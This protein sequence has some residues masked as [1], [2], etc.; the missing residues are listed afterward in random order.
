MTK[1]KT[2]R[3]ESHQGFSNKTVE[4]WRQFQ[5][6]GALVTLL[7]L[8]LYV[9]ATSGLVSASFAGGSEGG[10]AVQFNDILQVTGLIFVLS[11]ILGLYVANYE[12]RLLLRHLQFASLIFL[13]LLM[14][15][16]VKIVAY[17]N[18]SPYLISV[19]VLIT[20]I[21]I[22]IAFSQR[23]AVGI[24]AFM[25]LISL[26]TLER[27]L[28]FHVEFSIL[29][30]TGCAMFVTVACLR[31]IRTRSSLILACCLA[32]VVLF[33]MVWFMEFWHKVRPDQVMADSLFGMCGVILVGFFMQGILPLV[34]RVFQ[35]ATSMR[36][37][38]YSEASRPLLQRLAV[39]A[40]GTFHHSWQIG[41][42]AE[43]A[44]DAIGANGLLCRVGSYY[45]DIGKMNKPHF[46][47]ENQGE[48]FSQHKGLSPTMSK[49][50][51]IGHVKDGL[52][53]A[54]EYRLPKVLHQ[55]IATH[56]GT[57]LVEYFYHEATKG[58]KENG[59]S[60]NEADFRYPGPK[61]Q[62]K[63]TGI[64][65][66]CDAIEG[67]TRALAEP[68]PSRIE[69]IVNTLLMK[70]L[71]DGQFDECNLTMRELRLIENRL[72][73]TLCGMYH[74]RIAYPNTDAKAKLKDETVHVTQKVPV[75]QNP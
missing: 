24:G 9:A 34:E 6:C 40:P 20:A 54:L 39:D 30:S 64:V 50:I 68:T 19:P 2:K 7:Y 49:M 61:P 69:G 72:V 3:V 10:E 12:P 16:L 42:L 13:L 67:A 36:L 27:Q 32:G 23:F 33:A 17:L 58:E 59:L 60:L 70:R 28:N 48:S 29:L 56:H 25:T 1:K 35:T 66:L 71:L 51:I 15:V 75:G 26:L 14:T 5:G 44:A 63:E 65:M 55:F 22:N 11:F 73:S 41:M 4:L 21:I 8:L 37:L 46:F 45:H 62:N 47:V 31:E 52:E 57:T 43:A 74:G 53:M 18:W 38:D